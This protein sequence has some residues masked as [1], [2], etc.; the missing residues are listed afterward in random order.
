MTKC[1]MAHLAGRLPAH[2]ALLVLLCRVDYF[3]LPFGPLRTLNTLDY[4]LYF[5][6][7]PFDQRQWEFDIVLAFYS[8]VYIESS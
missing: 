2:L 8:I 4:E 3:V 5:S 6:A 1:P 7:F